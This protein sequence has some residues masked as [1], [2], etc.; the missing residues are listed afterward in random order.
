MPWL[1]VGGPDETHML[2]VLISDLMLLSNVL[3]PPPPV[4]PAWLSVRCWLVS[5]SMSTHTN[6]SVGVSVKLWVACVCFRVAGELRRLGDGGCTG[7]VLQPTPLPPK[8]SYTPMVSGKVSTPWSVGV[9]H[10]AVTG[11]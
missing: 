10:T 9:S 4:S 3:A 7:T 6:C 2:L 1:P 8:T 5:L 11:R